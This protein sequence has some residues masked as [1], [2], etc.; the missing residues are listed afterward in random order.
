MAC[1]IMFKYQIHC[2]QNIVYFYKMQGIL[3][4]YF[5]KQIKNAKN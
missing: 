1:Y 3:V 5:Q 4:T 2:L